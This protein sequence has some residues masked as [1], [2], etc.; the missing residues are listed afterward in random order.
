MSVDPQP[1]HLRLDKWL[2]AARFFKTR[3]LATAAVEGGKVSVNGAHAKPSRHL[4]EGDTLRI[5]RG[6]QE[7]TV[8]VQGLTRQRGSALVAH[9]LYEETAESLVAR[10]QRRE[11]KR[12]TGCAPPVRPDKRARRQLRRFS[13]RM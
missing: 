8:V 11:D 1:E 10:E 5:R 9:M 2:W 13:G 3:A 7:Y 6:E 12:L 4:H